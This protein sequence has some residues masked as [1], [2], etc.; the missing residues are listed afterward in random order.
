MLFIVIVTV[1]KNVYCEQVVID[2]VM[3][4]IEKYGAEFWRFS[5]PIIITESQH[6]EH[7]SES[8]TFCNV[9]LQRSR[10]SK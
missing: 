6:G 4:I 7:D 2:R 8:C 5:P 9:R 3:T 1:R 10:I